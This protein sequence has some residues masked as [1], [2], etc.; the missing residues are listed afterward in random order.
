MIYINGKKK[1][2]KKNK[3]NDKNIKQ[4]MIFNQKL[5]KIKFKERE[6]LKIQEKNYIKNF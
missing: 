5:I 1:L 2:I 6:F 4:I 3:N